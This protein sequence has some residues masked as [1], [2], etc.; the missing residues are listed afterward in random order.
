MSDYREI[1]AT[2]IA[3]YFLDNVNAHQEIINAFTNPAPNVDGQAF[4]LLEASDCTL[5]KNWFI[6]RCNE[7]TSSFL[8]NSSCTIKRS[9]GNI[10]CKGE[11]AHH[12]QHGSIDLIGVYYVNTLPKHPPLQI[13]ESRI[14]HKFNARSISK[15]GR[16]ITENV[17]YINIEPTMG[18]LVLFPGYLLHYVPTNMLEEPRISIAINVE[19]NF[20]IPVAES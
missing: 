19:V 10:Q 4:N 3:E 2:P 8:R 12:H 15:D 1:W 14:P 13:F 5:F 20:D 16:I 6:S 7:Y 18:K 9:W 17:R 11:Y